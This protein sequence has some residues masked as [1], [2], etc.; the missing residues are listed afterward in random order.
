MTECLVC[1]FQAKGGGYESDE[2]YQN[3]E[4]IFLDIA[5]I[6]VM[7]ER[8]RRR[9]MFMRLFSVWRSQSQVA[10]SDD[11]W[12]GGGGDRPLKETKRDFKMFEYLRRLVHKLFS[13]LI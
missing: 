10:T 13:S 5:N 4:L 7:R 6:H 12:G 3:T 11:G 1:L 2:F 9:F 8:Y